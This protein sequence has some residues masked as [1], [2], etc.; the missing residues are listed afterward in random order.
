LDAWDVRVRARETDGIQ[1]SPRIGACNKPGT[2][3]AQT[4]ANFSGIV[5]PVGGG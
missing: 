3:S 2:D 1:P 5:D 4:G